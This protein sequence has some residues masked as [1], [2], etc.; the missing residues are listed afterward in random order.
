[1]ISYCF[2]ENKYK[3]FLKVEMMNLTTERDP[4]NY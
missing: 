1:M 4:K 3:S 2:T